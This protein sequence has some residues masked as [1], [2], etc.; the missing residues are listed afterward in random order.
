MGADFTV[1][2]PSSGTLLQR[3]VLQDCDATTQR[4]LET[5]GGGTSSFSNENQNGKNVNS[6]IGWGGTE[7]Y[8]SAVAVANGADANDEGGAVN[9]GGAQLAR[10]LERLAELL[11]A[12][13][14]GCSRS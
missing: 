8:G 12:H 13:K 2:L 4:W 9:N 6:S 1:E 11:L 3:F 14:V 5:H 10:L 7:N